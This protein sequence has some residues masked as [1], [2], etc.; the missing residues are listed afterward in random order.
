METPPCY[1]PEGT[2]LAWFG[3]Q[4]TSNFTS[5]KHDAS[6][7]SVIQGCALSHNMW[8]S[9][10]GV[11]GVF[12]RCFYQ[13]QGKRLL[14]I[15]SIP[16][17]F[18]VLLSRI[19]QSFVIEFPDMVNL[20]IYFPCL[21]FCVVT[22]CWLDP[23]WWYTNII[24]HLFILYLLLESS[25]VLSKPL[26]GKYSFKYL[27]YTLRNK[28]LFNFKQTWGG[29]DSGNLHWS[30]LV[31][32][33]ILRLLLDLGLCLAL[34]FVFGNKPLVSK[35]LFSKFSCLL[36]NCLSLIYFLT[37]GLG[38]DSISTLMRDHLSIFVYV[39][40]WREI[41]KTDYL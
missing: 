23:Y 14:L 29:C 9:V 34:H 19:S 13:P 40:S 41:L 3:G 33:L 15:A 2:F 39:L 24:I 8:I 25:T 12:L 30:I 4:V 26:L 5:T 16:V 17:F 28:I 10:L 35:L 27:P 6:L 38:V 1:S 11:R 36:S 21:S 32:Q 18:R 37:K 7:N 22:L 20:F 31:Q